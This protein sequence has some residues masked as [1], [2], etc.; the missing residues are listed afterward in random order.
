MDGPPMPI[1]YACLATCLLF[2][3]TSIAQ[4]V[5]RSSHVWMLTEENH[6]YEDIVGNA[7]MP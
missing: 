4:S 5:P 6:S 2:A 3:T 1:R 7:Q